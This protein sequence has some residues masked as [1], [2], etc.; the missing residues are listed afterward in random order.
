MK[1]VVL[2]WQSYNTNEYIP[3]GTLTEVNSRRYLF[4]YTENA[5]RAQEEGC[6]LP[7]PYTDDFKVFE[8]LPTFFLQRLPI[9]EFN[10]HTFDIDIMG[11]TPLDLL[12]QFN[13]RKNNDNFIILADTEIRELEERSKTYVM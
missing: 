8:T 13:A 5:L 2:V 10:R 12:T 3:I 7:F 6:F 4:K 11:K 9:S 1:T